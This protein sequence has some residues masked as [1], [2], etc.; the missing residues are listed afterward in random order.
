[1]YLFWR[2][3]KKINFP[4]HI[5]FLVSLLVFCYI[6][7]FDV[8]RTALKLNPWYMLLGVSFFQRC[9]LYLLNRLF[10]Y[11]N[12][13]ISQRT[14]AGECVN[15]VVFSHKITNKQIWWASV[16]FQCKSL[17]LFCH[18]SRYFHCITSRQRCIRSKHFLLTV[19]EL[20]KASDLTELDIFFFLTFFFLARLHWDNSTS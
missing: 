1:M 5:I 2:W 19:G 12:N 20:A 8:K 6:F 13:E 15:S 9:R 3:W 10:V 11:G 16:L 7:I 17:E 18:K 4:K 14:N